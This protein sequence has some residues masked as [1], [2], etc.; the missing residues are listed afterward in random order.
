[1]PF[2]VISLHSFVDVITNSSSELFVCN[3]K[4]SVEAV[5]ATIEAL[6]EKYNEECDHRNHEY[7]FSP[8]RMEHIWTGVFSEPKA[9]TITL[10][11]TQF[12]DWAEWQ[13]AFG[14]EYRWDRKDKHPSFQ[15]AGKIMDEFNKAN[16]CPTCPDN[17]DEK[18]QEMKNYYKA[19]RK[20]YKARVKVEAVAY[21][22][23]YKIV[24]SLHTRLWL[25]IA[26]TNDLDL[27]PLGTIEVSGGEYAE[28]RW[29]REK[30][31]ASS[32]EL[33]AAVES[34]ED[35]LS[36]RYVVRKGD[37]LLRSA[38]DNSIPYGFW[39]SIEATFTCQRL[40]CG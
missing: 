14:G 16:P 21:K 30:L 3:T 23:W 38:D 22:E 24:Q 20:L 7:P 33:Q 34:I 39:D 6:A 26:K 1:M 37:V 2:T 15:E 19:L 35:A 36:W 8:V 31:E 10:E 18:S 17:T 32:P 4:K 9:S 5:K 29:N 25:W 28:G 12:P 40:H 27:S 11:V 13:K